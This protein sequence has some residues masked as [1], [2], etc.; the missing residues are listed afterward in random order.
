MKVTKSNFDEV[1][2]KVI[3]KLQLDK[4]V[5]TLLRERPEVNKLDVI[6]YPDGKI[7][8]VITSFTEKTNKEFYMASFYSPAL[9]H[10]QSGQGQIVD[11]IIADL[12]AAG[13]KVERESNFQ[14]P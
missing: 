14:Q 11:M 2:K 12:K 7:Q 8:L 6:D 3:N 4:D 13:R 9:I 10:T 5:L 1:T